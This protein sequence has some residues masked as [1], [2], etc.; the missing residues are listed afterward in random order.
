MVALIV[1]DGTNPIAGAM[2]SSN[3]A[4]ATPTRYNA[5]VGPYVL[6]DPMA[7]ET[8]TDGIAYVFRLPEGHV[9]VSAT[10]TG[11]TFASHGLKVWADELTTTV[12]VP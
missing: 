11:M 10:K 3:P 9:T 1:T 2:V 12:I 5:M 4:S 7:T 8:Y 6:P